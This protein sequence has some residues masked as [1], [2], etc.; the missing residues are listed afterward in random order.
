MHDEYKTGVN[1]IDIIKHLYIIDS[2]HIK[3]TFIACMIQFIRFFRYFL[4]CFNRPISNVAGLSQLYY[5]LVYA[6]SGN[7]KWQCAFTNTFIKLEVPLRKGDVDA[8]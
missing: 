2:E 8:L 6:C 1:Y 3:Q 7:L 4:L 5:I